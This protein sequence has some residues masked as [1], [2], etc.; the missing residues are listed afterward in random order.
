[1]ATHARIVTYAF[2]G[3]AIRGPVRPPVRG[4]LVTRQPIVRVRTDTFALQA[5]ILASGETVPMVSIVSSTN[6]AYRACVLTE[7]ARSQIGQVELFAKRTQTIKPHWYASGMNSRRN[8]T[9]S[10]DGKAA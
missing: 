9:M 4:S 7:L 3:T 2:L 1:M 10:R 6:S 8:S 5:V